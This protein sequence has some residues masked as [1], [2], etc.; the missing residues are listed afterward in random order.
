MEIAT[1]EQARRIRKL[2]DAFRKTFAGGKMVM[3]ASVA[4]LPEMVKSAALV[5]VAEFNDFTPENDPHG[6]HDF[7]SFEHC[8]RSFFWKC[9]YYNTEMD[10]GSED[11]ADPDKTTR[12][13]TLMLAE[14]Y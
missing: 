9:D 10:G 2:N 5:K 3:T 1:A 7:L 4:A 14:D 8:N 6:E 13:G 11:P 12:V